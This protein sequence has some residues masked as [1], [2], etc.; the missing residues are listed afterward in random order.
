MYHLIT[1]GKN[2][3]KTEDYMRDFEQRW[4]NDPVFGAR[5]DLMGGGRRIRRRM[6]MSIESV[7]NDD[8]SVGSMGS[9]ADDEDL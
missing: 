8:Y 7:N 2:K 3:H 1:Q 6:D 4:Q 5:F 9:L